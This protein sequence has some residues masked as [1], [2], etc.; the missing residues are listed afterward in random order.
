MPFWTSYLLRVYWQ[1]SSVG[2]RLNQVLVVLGIVPRPSRSSS[3]TNRHVHRHGYVYVPFAALVLY[4]WLKRF[5][6]QPSAAQ[7][8]GAALR[9]M[10]HLLLPR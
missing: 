7:D 8:L 6:L 5:E 3:T 2:R 4:A 1:A 10:P 9:A